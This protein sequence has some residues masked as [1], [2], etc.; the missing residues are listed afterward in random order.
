VASLELP[1][2]QTAR[3]FTLI[4]RRDVLL[5]IALCLLAAV[6]LWAIT[7]AWSSPFSYRTGYLPP[8]DIVARLPFSIPDEEKTEARQRQKRS[9]AIC[10]Y[11]HDGRPLVELQQALKDDVFEL[12]N[13][14]DASELSDDYWDKLTADDPLS[15]EMR[16][17]LYDNIKA[18]LEQDMELAE[19]VKSVGQAFAPFAN[20]GLLQ[21]L[22]HELQD[23]SQQAVLIHPVGNPEFVHRVEVSD[24]RIAEAK[25]G[26]VSRLREA[27]GNGGVPADQAD[28]VTNFVVRWID[29]KG[30]PVTLVINE[31]ASEAARKQLV[32]L[33]EPATLDYRV[34]AKLADGGQPLTLSDIELLRIEHDA[35]RAQMTIG[36]MIRQSLAAFGM[37]TA[38]F[39]LC[40][41]YLFFNK[42]ILLVSLR[43]FATM[44]ALAVISIAACWLTASDQ[45]RAESIP[46]VLF[47]MTVAIAYERELA[48]LLSAV[49]ALIVSLSLGQGLAE[50]VILVAS[51]SVS[52][53]L[54]SRVRSRTKLIYVGCCAAVVTFLTAM[55][56]GT[57]VG[58]AF[59][60]SNVAR[61]NFPVGLAWSAEA[62]F[63][64]AL[65][66]GA[67]WHGF[68]CVLA[69]VLMT[70]LLPFIEKIF[71]TQT[72]LSLLELGDQAHPLLQE[73]ARRA[74][75][76]YN[77]SINVASLAESAAESIGANALL[78][79]VGAYFHDIGK[80]F[81]PGYFVENQGQSDNRH[82]SLAPAM[83]TLVIIAHVKDGADLARQHHL[84]QTI[85]NFIEQHHG[86]TLVE[87]FYEQAAKQNDPDDGE[88]DEGSF[89]YPGPKPQTREAGVMMLA[90]AVESA[91]R[92]LVE[93]APA[94]IES[95]VREI[96][97][98]KLLD[99]QFE[100]CAL[101]MQELH[102][103]EDSLVKS[104]TAVYHARVKYP[105][106]QT[107]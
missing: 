62:S 47:G 55:G 21:T 54:L 74:P 75:G 106:Q 88:V 25:T 57:M 87:Y 73:L 8:R 3:F 16:N 7:G 13:A 53:L 83:S 101:T 68:C 58:Q 56:V 28:N 99:G 95:L 72:D 107:A 98:K 52:I 14:A 2:G 31:V 81:K 48:L 30:L 50:F 5:R 27:F 39:M 23:G 36:Q 43:R 92:S 18:S 10:V 63:A 97:M 17:A 96:M 90:D 82:E 105:D 12:L 78:V 4:R 80:M 70:G 1:P 20:D 60:L 38:M 6:T 29:T 65:L 64:A 104:L 66:T 76:T 67:A 37:Y 45:W 46:L 42:R 89:R 22:D 11:A 71:G 91:A 85:I 19:F 40:G 44:L 102:T 15:V 41:S 79:R 77:H 32:D 49:V 86:T 61:L 34:G 24:V 94:R 51:V 35:Q 69:G 33:V 84:P 26:L 59:G 103:I 100:Q 9:E 93:P